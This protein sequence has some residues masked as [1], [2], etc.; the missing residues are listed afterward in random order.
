[1]ATKKL[2][3]WTLARLFDGKW[4]VRFKGIELCL[5]HVYFTR[6]EALHIENML[7][8]LELVPGG[9]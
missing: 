6:E 3:V 7:N 8:K 9:R 4:S 2:Q 5:M 1:M